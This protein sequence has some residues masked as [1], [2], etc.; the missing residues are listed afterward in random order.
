LSRTEV[1]ESIQVFRFASEHA[2]LTANRD[3]RSG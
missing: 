1:I 3:P 2:V